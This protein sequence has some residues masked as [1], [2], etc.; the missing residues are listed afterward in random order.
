[1]VVLGALVLLPRLASAAEEPCDPA[2]NPLDCVTSTTDERT[3]TT[4]DEETTTTEDEQ[5]DD[6]STTLRRTT[7]TEEITSSTITITTLH[8]VLI[9]GD[10]T[11][12]A[13]STTTTTAPAVTGSS[14]VSD[15]T[16]IMAIVIAL[17]IVAVVVGVLTFRYWSA[18]RPRVVEAPTA[19]TARSTFLD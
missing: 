13:E 1:L 6:T 3:T 12:G 15:E 14:G 9:P 4:A 17:G 16:L 11:A 8:D 7:T 19:R 18:T 2:T 5:V 10:G